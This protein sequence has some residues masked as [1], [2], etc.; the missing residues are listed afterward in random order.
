[1]NKISICGV[2]VI[3]DPLVC[4]FCVFHSAV[5]EIICGAVVSCLVFLRPKF[6]M[7]TSSILD[8]FSG[9]LLSHVHGLSYKRTFPVSASLK[10]RFE[11]I[12]SIDA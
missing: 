9:R 3:L 5:C 2:A 7:L 10:N 6:S 1:M 11:G 4:D 12:N 8:S